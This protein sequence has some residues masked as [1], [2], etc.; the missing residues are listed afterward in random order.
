MRASAF[1][2]QIWQK[3]LLLPVSMEDILNET[4]KHKKILFWR[5][6]DMPDGIAAQL[7]LKDDTLWFFSNNK[8]SPKNERIVFARFLIDSFN[9]NYKE[10]YTYNDVFQKSSAYFEA[11]RILLPRHA[12]QTLVTRCKVNSFEKLSDHMWIEQSHI[13]NLCVEDNIF[14]MRIFSK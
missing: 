7:E 9:K 10:E 3:S 2:N 5:I 12:L 6:R 13:Y 4:N 8:L 1:Y 11:L 14:G